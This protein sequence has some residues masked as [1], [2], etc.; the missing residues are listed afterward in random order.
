[1]RLF[2][3]VGESIG[4]LLVDIFASRYGPCAQFMRFPTRRD[5]AS[6]QR[7][8]DA[9]R[10]VARLLGSYVPRFDYQVQFLREGSVRSLCDSTLATNFRPEDRRNMLWIRK[11]GWQ[12]I[13]ER[14]GGHDQFPAADNS[15]RLRHVG[16][17]LSQRHVIGG[18]H[19]RG[20][21]DIR[22]GNV[23]CDSATQYAICAI[24][25]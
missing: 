8:Y 13:G 10:A 3:S 21:S 6:Q 24:D 17:F 15:P 25:G 1:M 9:R 23:R 18:S 5:T 19:S 4:R 7:F 11:S 14:I 22:L 12:L 20:E 2:F 16:S